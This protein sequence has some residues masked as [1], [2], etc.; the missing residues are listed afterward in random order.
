[1]KA[2]MYQHL[3]ASNDKNG[4]PRRIFVL[5]DEKGNVVTAI[6]EGYGGRPDECRGLIQLPSYNISAT[7]YKEILR[8]KR[9]AE[10]AKRVE[11]NVRGIK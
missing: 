5:L 4:N 6:D 8:Q 11:A 7:D 2:T 1:M 9:K 10:W 3:R